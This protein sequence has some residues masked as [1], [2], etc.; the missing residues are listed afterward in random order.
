MIKLAVILVALI[1]F[2]YHLILGIVQYRSANNPT[3]A[4]VSDVYDTET[5]LKWKKY[6][7]E[8]CVLSLAS[9]AASFVATVCLLFTNAYASFA[10]LFPDTVFW[11]LFAVVLLE[12]IADTVFSVIKSYIST[13]IIEEKYGFNRSSAK[14]FV[15]DIIR[16]TLLGFG[17]SLGM[18]CAL[19]GIHAAFGDWLILLF[20]AVL[21]VFTLVVSFLY[22]IFSRIGNKFTPLEEGELKDRLMSLLTDHGY[23]V[24]AIEVMD[25]SRRT[26]KLN[27]YFTG[28]GKM[29]TIVLYDNLV[30][31][32]TPDEICA[33]FA[34][35]LGHG[36]HKDVLKRQIMNFG[37]LLIMACAVW[38][39]VREPALHTAFGFDTVNYGFAYILLGLGLGLIQPL[40]GLVT[41]AYSRKAEFRADRQSVKEGYGEAM[42]TALKKLARENF[43][44][45]SPSKLN[46]V[47][48]YSHPPLAQRIEAVEKEIT[49]NPA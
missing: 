4:S 10:S 45:L 24:K 38:F 33:V 34:H 16:N 43:A 20:A 23:K 21:F 3:P 39:A 26:T 19:W 2:I 44:H 14:T 40:T 6:S 32:M 46:V 28:F 17:L 1:T 42:I 48:D 7:G 49:K 47:M 22:P 29:K 8:N 15:F 9:T 31:S 18:V 27:A 13:M 12:T 41:N 30:N 5:Y 37:N 11:G 25:A 35:E 36:L